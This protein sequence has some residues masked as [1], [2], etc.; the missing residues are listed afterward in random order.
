MKK[1]IW[2]I[3]LAALTAL[4]VLLPGA[5][6]EATRG[7]FGEFTGNET[8]NAELR[9]DSRTPWLFDCQ[10]YY[11]SSTLPKILRMENAYGRMRLF[12][13]GDRNEGTIPD[14]C[15]LEFISG[16]E[17]LREAIYIEHYVSSDSDYRQVALVTDSSRMTEP[18]EAV[19]RFRAKAGGLYYEKEFTF[20]VLSW[21]EEPLFDLKNGDATCFA[22]KGEGQPA[23]DSF[24][25]VSENQKDR[26]D[27][28]NLYT[29]N[30]LVSMLLTDHSRELAEKYL[31]EEQRGRIAEYLQDR[32]STRYELYPVQLT[33][34]DTYPQ[35]NLWQGWIF[36]TYD[37]AFQF[38]AFGD[39][40]FG[41]HSEL[42]NVSAEVTVHV[43]PYRITGPTSLMP[44]ETGRFT[45]TDEDEPAGRSFTLNCEGNGMH[46]DA[47]TGSLTVPEDSPEGT[48][49]TVTAVP[50]D[51]GYSLKLTGK[52]TK[53]LITGET[54]EPFT[55]TEG[56]TVPVVS[57][58]Q[59]FGK[60]IMDERNL[61]FQT[62][63]SSAP[64]S[65]FID[66]KIYAPLDEFAE[67]AETAD[68]MYDYGN[69]TSGVEDLET[70]SIQL[71]EHH[72]RAQLM[73][74]PNPSGDYS[75]GMLYYVR[76]NRIIRV[77]IF[78]EPQNGTAWED[79][80][81]V[82]M[83]DLRKIA[84][85]IVYD[86]SQASITVADGGISLSTKDGANVVSAGKK[87]TVNAAFASPEKVNKKAKNDGITW[88]VTEAETGNAPEGITVDKK[89]VLTAGKQTDR[90]TKVEV[91]AES[92][93]FHTSATYSVT[94]IPAMKKLAVEPAEVFFYT[95]T[96]SQVTARAVPD[97]ETVP[98]TGITWTPAKQGIVEIVPDE[99]NGSAVIRPVGAGK[100]TIAVREPGGK[101]AKLAVSVVAPAEEL[102]LTVS[103]KTS[104]GSTVTVKETVL[105]K[106][107]GNKA[108]EWS[109]DVEE[110]IATISKGKVKITKTA[111]EGAVI[112]VTCTA[113]GAPEP[114]VRTVQ[115]TVGK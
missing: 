5:S 98:A 66:Y 67:D 61:S 79:L 105:P 43:L 40:P 47:D 95:G 8:V 62:L 17:K 44:G 110:D 109:L 101:N 85:Q 83:G 80:P 88:S 34:D 65:I 114:I 51:G 86:P 112:T 10:I 21:K 93:V 13:P 6:G 52:V 26:R 7:N 71:G 24:G 42:T 12:Q 36:M 56:F 18:G 50:S 45:V 16:D 25:H 41:F 54:F 46:F 89:G 4:A 48:M 64:S 87:L 57:D 99:E 103:G 23:A 14:A 55:M 90:V 32:D 28:T 77:R 2:I 29:A 3:A 1:R 19:F 92:P 38:M 78:S 53:G 49:Y 60:T 97:P 27:N 100:T 115:I 70:E 82:T 111:P 31:D 91:K 75:L 94:V 73:K 11:A 59:V 22:Q 35:E 84:E 15:S 81:K 63:D 39:Y 9:G 74:V 20:R 104:P 30:Q 108:V 69:V 37:Q 102:E 58:E 33:D 96:D 76:N 113:T 68:R 107:A 106:Q 72:A